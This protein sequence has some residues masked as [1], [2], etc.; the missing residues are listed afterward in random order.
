MPYTQQQYR[1]GP[2]RAFSPV[3]SLGDSKSLLTWED[4]ESNIKLVIKYILQ[5]N[6]KKEQCGFMSFKFSTFWCVGAL[7]T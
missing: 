2:Q 7:E 6:F 5:K 4:C 3:W 1:S